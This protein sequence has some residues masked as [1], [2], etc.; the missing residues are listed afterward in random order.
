[1]ALVVRSDQDPASLVGSIIAEIRAVDPEQAVYDVRPMTE[2]VDR[3]IGQ[4]WLTTAVLSAFAIVSL[5]MS[6]IG[7]YGVVSYGV[8]QRAHEFSVRMALGA[9]KRDVLKLVL[10]RG[11]VLAG[12]G[13]AIGVLAA[14]LA[15]RALRTLLHDVS[16]TDVV[17]FSAATGVL[18]LA[19]LLATIIPARR[20][21]NVEP[22]AALRGE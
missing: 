21:V 8:R 14:L 10:V 11:A 18:A 6:T 19:A 22:M 7:V 13:A 16:A 3:S 12:C 2:V 4:Q 20:A 9:A 5:L 15:T 17:S 1:M